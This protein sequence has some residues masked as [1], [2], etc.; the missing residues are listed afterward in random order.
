MYIA[1]FLFLFLCLVGF[2]LFYSS[3][4]RL[5]VYLFVNVYNCDVFVYIIVVLIL[6]DVWWGG[7]GG[8]VRGWRGLLVLTLLISRPCQYNMTNKY[9]QSLSPSGSSPCCCWS[10]HCF[11][12]S[13]GTWSITS[14]RALTG[15][16]SYGGCLY[17]QCCARF[18]ND[19]CYLSLT[20]RKDKPGQCSHAYCS[21]SRRFSHI[22]S[23]LSTGTRNL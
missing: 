9:T 2:F 17:S 20:L 4:I 5:C 13:N 6:G 15:S 11:L 3:N 18:Y 12:Y 14:P 8:G 22:G 21:C 19:W 7:W 23:T 1:I 10:G 16:I